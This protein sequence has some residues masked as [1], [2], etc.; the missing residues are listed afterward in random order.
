MEPALSLNVG[1]VGLF[2]GVEH[3]EMQAGAVDANIGKPP[4]ALVVP[5]SA[6]K[7]GGFAVSPSAENILPVH[8]YGYVS[9]VG[10]S[11]IG[12]I[13]ID[14]IYDIERPSPVHVD[15][16]ETMGL[17]RGPTNH[18]YAIPL[19]G[20]VPGKRAG[21]RRPSSGFDPSENAGFW[22]VVK[23]FLQALCSK[24]GSSHDAP[25]ML[26]GQRPAM[27][28]STGGPRHFNGVSV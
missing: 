19:L 14:V 26:I 6:S 9:K 1:G 17:V 28:I 11:V 10:D 2:S 24:I 18:Y 20:Y 27:C 3:A 25:L 15:P 23:K 4:Q 5:K 16:C 7:A 8:R 22:I 21:F 13:A 12:F